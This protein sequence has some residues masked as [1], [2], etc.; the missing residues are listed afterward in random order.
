MVTQDA[1]LHNYVVVSMEKSGLPI[2][3][4]DHLLAVILQQLPQTRVAVDGCP[5]IAVNDRGIARRDTLS[6]ADGRARVDITAV[7]HNV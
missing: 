3:I 2:I 6:A 4:V 7:E 1:V 5:P